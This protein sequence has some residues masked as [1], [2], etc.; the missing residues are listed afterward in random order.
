MS[1]R[2]LPRGGVYRA[3]HVAEVGMAISVNLAFWFLVQVDTIYVNKQLPDV[4][5][6]G[7]AAAS[8]LGK[9]LVY[10]PVAVGHVLFPLLIA[11]RTPAAGRRM[12]LRMLL[13]TVALDA[14]GFAIIV[15][16]PQRLLLLTL[17]ETYIAAVPLLLPVAAVLAPFAVASVFMYD[18]L[19][20]HDRVITAI[21]AS[22]AAVTA[23]ALI[24]IQPALR[25]LFA[26]LATGAVI[27]IAGGALRTAIARRDRHA[28]APESVR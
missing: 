14:I 20:R 12:L 3:L 9:M 1:R 24:T 19:S 23:V 13:V 11:T 4:A 26:V 5:L 28:V 27:A 22:A 15:V 17:G 7:Y 21:F 8:A 10:I 2:G 18:A 16:S 6:H 25:T